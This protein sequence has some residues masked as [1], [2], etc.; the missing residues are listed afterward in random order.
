MDTRPRVS[1]GLPVYNGE[2]YL[3]ETLDSLLAQTFDDFELIIVDNASTDGTSD[4]CRAYAANDR[5]IRYERNPSNIGV[6]RNCNK[7]FRLSSGEYYKLACA[8]DICHPKL[9]ARC[10]A[11]L[12]ADPAIVLSYAKTRFIDRRGQWLGISDPGWHLMSDAPQERMRYVIASG[13]W[14]NAFYGLTRSKDLA[15]TRLFPLY[16]GGDCRLLGELCLRGKFFEIPETLFFRRLHPDAASQ[17]DGLDWH[18][19]FFRGV[20][21]HVDLPF[22]HICLDHTTTILHSELSARHK[23]S[24]LARLSRRMFD[25]KRGLLNE[26]HLASKYWIKTWLT[27]DPR[28]NPVNTPGYPG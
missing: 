16:V 2:K 12:D 18:S 25:G 17:H 14:V 6:Y 23:I 28:T 10:V 21:G 20:R 26:L 1:I 15:Q 9:L 8:D 19:E 24:C 22:W 27:R 5:R 7:A 11:V 13:H 4:V 3:A